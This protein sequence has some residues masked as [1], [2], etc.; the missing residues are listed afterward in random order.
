MDVVIVLGMFL[1]VTMAFVSMMMGIPKDERTN[2]ID[3]Q[4]DDG[5]RN[6]FAAGT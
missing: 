6:R 4:T 5:D 3:H 2:D 1:I